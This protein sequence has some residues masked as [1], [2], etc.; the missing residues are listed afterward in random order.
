[1]EW[2]EMLLVTM[3]SINTCINVTVFFR[4]RKIKKSSSDADL[5]L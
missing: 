1:M 5:A 3:V 4:G 2:W